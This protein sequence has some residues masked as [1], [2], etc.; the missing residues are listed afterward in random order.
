MKKNICIS[1]YVNSRYPLDLSKLIIL[2]SKE[3]SYSIQMYMCQRVLFPNGSGRAGAGRNSI[4]YPVAKLGVG[5]PFF[6][7]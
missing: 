1:I 5:T 6:A 2:I 7:G 3:I 4:S